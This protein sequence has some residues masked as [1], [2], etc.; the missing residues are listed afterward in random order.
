MSWLGNSKIDEFLEGKQHSDDKYSR[1]KNN[2]CN[3]YLVTVYLDHVNV[4]IIVSKELNEIHYCIYIYILV[5]I[6]FDC[7]CKVMEYFNDKSSSW[8][9]V[10]LSYKERCLNRKSNF[11]GSIQKPILCCS[12][13]TIQCTNAR[14]HKDNE[15]K[16]FSSKDYYPKSKNEI[17]LFC[18][19]LRFPFE[20]VLTK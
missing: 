11:K 16:T 2:A 1:S 20:K 7:F 12:Y 10:I 3:K 19:L 5:H 17:S 14:E 18:L 9:G 8:Y 6:Y 4:R 13:L 15:T